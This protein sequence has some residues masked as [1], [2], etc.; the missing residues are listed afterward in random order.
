MMRSLGVMEVGELLGVTKKCWAP[1]RAAEGALDVTL[2][3]SQE[4]QGSQGESGGLGD[5][6]R[7]LSWE[8]PTRPWGAGGAEAPACPDCGD[9]SAGCVLHAAVGA[10]GQSTLGPVGEKLQPDAQRPD[11]DRGQPCS[12]G[13]RKQVALKA[14]LGLKDCR[15][16]RQPGLARGGLSP[17][18]GPC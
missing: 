4:Y 18:R 13:D 12:L 15:G 14:E 5:P 1:W 3:A 17:Q 9:C 2:P 8:E 10:R 6:R 7:V 16:R 11:G